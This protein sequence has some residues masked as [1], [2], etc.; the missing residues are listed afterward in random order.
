MNVNLF[1]NLEIYRTTPFSGLTDENN[2][3]KAMLTAPAQMTAMVSFLMGT[4]D[5]GSFLDLISGGIG[6][7]KEIESNEYRWKVM[8][9]G[10]RAINIVRAAGVNQAGVFA[11]TCVATDYYGYN[12]SPI[13]IWTTED[14]FGPQQSV[15]YRGLLIAI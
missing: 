13:T 14:Y 2:L 4:K 12:G 15:R 6:H 5:N 1:S 8:I 11:D 9:D 10:D 7:V 3:R